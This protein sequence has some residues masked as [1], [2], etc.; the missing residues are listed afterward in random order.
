MGSRP[1]FSFCVGFISR[2][3]AGTIK[4]DADMMADVPFPPY[5]VQSWLWMLGLLFEC[6]THL[7]LS[8]VPFMKMSA[9]F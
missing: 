9:K 1:G 6:V 8:P 4:L 3:I 5:F 7:Y 2:F